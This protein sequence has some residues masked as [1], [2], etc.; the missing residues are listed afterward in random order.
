MIFARSL[1]NFGKVGA[2]S[3]GAALACGLGYVVCRSLVSWLHRHHTSG[4]SLNIA[5]VCADNKCS[6]GGGDPVIGLVTHARVHMTDRGEN[7]LAL[8]IVGNP[9]HSEM[10]ALVSQLPQCAHDSINTI[11]RVEAVIHWFVSPSAP[12]ASSAPQATE[13]LTSTIA[14]EQAESA[15]NV[16][17]SLTQD[18]LAM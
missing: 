10:Q 15:S 17:P 13:S 8:E 18:N 2:V 14:T 6:I 12:V 7:V 11:H 3:A 1:L 5:Y 4:Q 16:Y 9:L